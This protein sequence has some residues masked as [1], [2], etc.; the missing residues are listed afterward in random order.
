MKIS[1]EAGAQIVQELDVTQGD[2]QMHP[3]L[4]AAKHGEAK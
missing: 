4:R 2:E 1:M 3:L